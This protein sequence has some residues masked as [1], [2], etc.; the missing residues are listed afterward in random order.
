M[1]CKQQLGNEAPSFHYKFQGNTVRRQETTDVTMALP[2][3]N[4][5]M[6]S[7]IQ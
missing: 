3:R 1:A 5:Q 2:M 6:F 7:W 4:P